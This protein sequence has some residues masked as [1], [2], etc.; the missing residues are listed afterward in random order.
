MRAYLPS[1]PSE[2]EA[3]PSRLPPSPAIP[4]LWDAH[5]PASPSPLSPQPAKMSTPKGRQPIHAA[6]RKSVKTPLSRLVLEKAVR[7]KSKEAAVLGVDGGRRT[8]VEKRTTSGAV[9]TLKTARSSSGSSGMAS[10]AGLKSSMK[11]VK[12]LAQVQKRPVDLSRSTGVGP[13]AAVSRPA[14]VWR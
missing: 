12:T 2:P 5:R 13:A 11:P 7:S 10:N 3:G 4:P 1:S 6:R 9:E 8:N 14:K